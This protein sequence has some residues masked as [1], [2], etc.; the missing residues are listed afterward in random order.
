MHKR[1][2]ADGNLYIGALFFAKI[3]GNIGLFKVY[4][5]IVL[6]LQSSIDINKIICITF[7]Y[8]KCV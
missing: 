7:V 8:E 2:I 3:V 1:D 4:L 6:W 5:K